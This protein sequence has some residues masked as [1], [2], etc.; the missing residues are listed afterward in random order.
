MEM[1]LRECRADGR[2]HFGHEMTVVIGCAAT[3]LRKPLGLWPGGEALRVLV[4]E[5]QGNGD[6]AEGIGMAPADPIPEL[7]ITRGAIAGVK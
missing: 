5:A 2:V 4:I 6:H 7:S 3:M 1:A